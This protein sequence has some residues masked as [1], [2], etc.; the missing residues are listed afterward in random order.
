MATK[1]ESVPEKINGTEISTDGS[2]DS[3]LYSIIFTP[4]ANV[5]LR[6]PKIEEISL[7][8]T[9]AAGFEV[10]NGSVYV[11]LHVI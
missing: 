1:S 7:G 6:E 3:A 11:F 2:D 5:S 9:A 8:G 4:T 10:Y